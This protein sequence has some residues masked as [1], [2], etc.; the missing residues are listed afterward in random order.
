MTLADQKVTRLAGFN[1]KK[2]F[3]SKVQLLFDPFIG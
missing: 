1:P 3:G 2:M